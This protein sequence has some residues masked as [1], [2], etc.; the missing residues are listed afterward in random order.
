MT[1]PTQKAV[2]SAAREIATWQEYRVRD[3]LGRT[4]YSK[5]TRV[6]I[7]KPRWMPWRLFLALMRCVV[8]E[9]RDERAPAVPRTERRDVKRRLR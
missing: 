4:L 7:R 6:V 8:I 2:Q 5:A 9:E 1:E 3:A